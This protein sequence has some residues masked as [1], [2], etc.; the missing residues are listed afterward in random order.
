MLD[1]AHPTRAR[2]WSRRDAFALA[3]ACCVTL[4]ASCSREPEPPPPVP[5]PTPT[6][7]PPPPPPPP[8]YAIKVDNIAAARP[9]VGLAAADVIVIEP[10]E[11]GL[12]RILAVYAG[13]LP[14]TVGPVRS[15]RTTDIELLAQLGEPT[16]AYSGAAPH[17]LSALGDAPLVSASE[18]AFAAAFFRDPARR[19]PHNLYV[20]PAQLPPP[21][22]E[23]T[24][25]VIEFGSAPEGGTETSSH[26][27]GYQRATY[28]FAWVPEAGRWSITLDGSPMISAGEGDLSTTNVVVQE[29]PVTI[30]PNGSPLAATVGEGRVTVLREGLRFDGR[31]HRPA[32]EEPTRYTTDEGAPLPLQEGTTWVLL[33]PAP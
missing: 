33:V 13:D 21:A 3:A 30:E 27:V 26:R 5:E 11:Y 25:P 10:V 14:E 32:R 29:V 28:D 23:P 1:A 20:R 16:F 4:L 31:W 22:R 8:M 17:V 6:P 15:A 18:Q 24:Q 2:Q 19:A 12:T 9:H 7:E